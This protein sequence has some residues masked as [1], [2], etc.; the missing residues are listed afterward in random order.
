MK[1]I[2]TLIV[3]LT[4]NDMTVQNAA[5]VFH[6]CRDAAATC[7][8]FK[9]KGLPPEEM[10]RLFAEMREAGKTTALEVVAYTEAEGLHGAETAAACGCDMLMGTMFFD[11]VNDFCRERGIR[12]CPFIGEVRD[13]PSVLE[14]SAERMIDEAKRYLAKGAYGVD[15]LGYRYTGDG[16]ALNRQ[17][18]EAVPGPVCVAGSVDSYERLAELKKIAPWGFTIGSAFFDHRFGEDF[19]AQIDAVCAFMEQ[20]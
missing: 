4:Y 11:S 16:A 17:V 5:E 13:R 15:L 2:P 10:K 12:Y 6:R 19:A 1:H 18:V 7:W 8:G 3:M 9:E 20:P 14:G